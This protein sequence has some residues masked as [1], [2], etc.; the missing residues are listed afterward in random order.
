MKRKILI[1]MITLTVAMIPICMQ[2]QAP[3]NPSYN[4]P[5]QTPKINNFKT[6]KNSYLKGSIVKFSGSASNFDSWKIVWIKGSKIE[7]MTGIQNNTNITFTP[8]VN[9]TEY[10]GA[11][12]FVY[13]QKNGGGVVQNSG[14]TFTVIQSEFQTISS[15]SKIPTDGGGFLGK[16]NSYGGSGEGKQTIVYLYIPEGVARN[17]F[18][19][20]KLKDLLTITAKHFGVN[21]LESF[22]KNK[23]EDKVKEYILDNADKL[24]KKGAQQTLKN[25][26][27][28]YGFYDNAMYV[29]DLLN[30][31]VNIGNDNNLTKAL[32]KVETDGYMIVNVT[33][34]G[35]GKDRSVKYYPQPYAYNDDTK[36]IRNVPSDS[37]KALK[38]S[39]NDAR[40]EYY[41]WFFA[42]SDGFITD[43]LSM[44]EL[45]SKCKSQFGVS[46]STNN[47]SGVSVGS[48][49]GNSTSIVRQISSQKFPNN[50]TSD[51][52][53]NKST[54][55]YSNWQTLARKGTLPA[56][57]QIKVTEKIQL[58]NGKSY[59]WFDPYQAGLPSGF[60]DAD[61][62]RVDD[63]NLAGNSGGGLRA[64]TNNNSNNNTNTVVRQISSQKFPNNSTSDRWTNKSTAVYSNWQTL[65]RKGTLP[66]GTRIKVTEKIQLSNGKSY[67]WFDPYQAGLPSGFVDADDLRVDDPNLGG[68]SGS[69]LRASTNNNSNNNTN[70]VVR[71]QPVISISVQNNANSNVRVGGTFSNAD[72][73]TIDCR[74]LN[75]NTVMSN[76]NVTISGNSW[77]YNKPV[78][79]GKR[80][81]F[82]VKAT[83]SG[84]E[85]WA[86][87]EVTAQVAPQSNPSPQ[88]T[89]P[90]INI[91]VKSNGNGTIR[92]G[93][94]YS[95]AD[96]IS[97]D[98]RNLV[99]NTVIQN[100]TVQISGGNWWYDKP[101]EAGKRYRFA[102]KASKNG[103]DIWQQLEITAY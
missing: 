99:M 103:V 101:V 55:V 15:S 20:A 27:I 57:A 102:V 58:S 33:V 74:N 85:K 56:G 21:S 11:I 35:I 47:N 30:V 13:S 50:S 2:A 82:A 90:S 91:S 40:R 67:A 49:N 45:T 41:T 75:D 64:S 96:R 31:C 29:G 80:Y 5:I 71:Q 63:P 23:L 52:W 79:G 97:L 54:A 17:L 14:I 8:T 83:N 61:D 92:V 60:V 37:K 32:S 94:T 72:K 9:S 43:F 62:L 73:I 70:T 100:Q 44:T 26:F 76:Q 48:G 93:G 86:E 69:G 81:R 3:A 65:A 1:L 36:P 39:G 68:S 89:T 88:V 18:T 19:G 12:L 38:E 22:A 78:E 66:A 28:V 95:N 16:D 42:Y 34:T 77:Y 87:T 98:C 46:L 25:I 6:D 84:G 51:R 4:M 10:N 24:I 7:S 53:T 59:A